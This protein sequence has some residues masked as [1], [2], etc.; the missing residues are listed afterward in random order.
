VG[1]GVGDY[2][3]TETFIGAIDEL[4]TYGR[5]LTPAEVWELYRAGRPPRAR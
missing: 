5:A 2:Q 3:P 4:R 1:A